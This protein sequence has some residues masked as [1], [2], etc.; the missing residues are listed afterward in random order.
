MTPARNARLPRGQRRQSLLVAA[1]EV[2]VEAGYHAASMDDIAAAAGVTK[3]V[4][5]QHFGSKRDLYLAVLDAGVVDFIMSV[6]KGLQSDPDNR[7]RVMATIDAYL[8]FISHDDAVYRLVFESDLVNSPDV[9]E[10]VERANAMSA[11]LV[12]EVI[13]ADTGLSRE[14]ATLL[15]YGLL[16]MAETAARHWLKQPGTMDRP[17]AAQLLAALAWRGIS[18]FPL[19]HPPVDRNTMARPHPRPAGDPMQ[20]RAKSED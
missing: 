1:R 17:A 2:F 8:R 16:G 15:A 11:D 7:N 14:E 12:S 5:Y 20:P 10:R 18:G 19:S 9:R 13:A 6:G 4:L 3:P